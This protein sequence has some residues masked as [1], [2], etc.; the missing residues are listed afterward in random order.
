MNRYLA[1]ETA[2]SLLKDPSTKGKIDSAVM[3]S[4]IIIREVP[5]E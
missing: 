1:T 2:I 3:I 5:A 4:E